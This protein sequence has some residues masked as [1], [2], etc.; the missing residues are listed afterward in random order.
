MLQLILFNSVVCDNRISDNASLRVVFFQ[1]IALELAYFGFLA[2]VLVLKNGIVVRM[3]RL[4]LFYSIDDNRISDRVLP[5]FFFQSFALELAYFGFLASVLMLKNGRV[6]WMLPLFVCT[7]VYD[8]RISD[9][10]LPFFLFLSIFCPR[11]GVLSL[12]GF[13]SHVQKRKS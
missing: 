2:S 10:V 5:C 1:S 3:L 13:F 7:I 6:I 11:I 12:L 4:I 8:N 9:R